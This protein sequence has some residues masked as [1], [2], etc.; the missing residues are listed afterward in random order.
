[1]GSEMCI[2]DRSTDH[3]AAEHCIAAEHMN[4]DHTES[5]HTVTEHCTEAEHCTE[6]GCYIVAEPGYTAGT[7]HCTVAVRTESVR[8][9]RSNLQFD[10]LNHSQ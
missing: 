6:I 3:I 9:S 2:R 7:D 5:D 10:Y 8:Q 4:S 1:M